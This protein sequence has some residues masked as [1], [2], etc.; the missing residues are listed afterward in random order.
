MGVDIEG[1]KYKG[2]GPAFPEGKHTE[3]EFDAYIEARRRFEKEHPGYYFRSN[4]WYWRP[5]WDYTCAVCSDL[6]T[7]EQHAAGH[8]NCGPLLDA[9]QAEAVGK[10]LSEV[11][12]N[13]EAQEYDEAHKKELA[14]LPLEECKICGGTGKRQAPPMVGPGPIDCNG[15][16]GKGQHE[17]HATWYNFDL[18]MLQEFAEFLKDSGGMEVW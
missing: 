10:R 5:L 15:C 12:A 13:G 14:E 8:S 7:P 1:V 9:A 2:Q 17:S 3:E 4:W 18:E 6:I 16:N 11:I